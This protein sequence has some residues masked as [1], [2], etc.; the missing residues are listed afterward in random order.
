[1]IQMKILCVAIFTIF[2]VAVGLS[3]TSA[4]AFEL[5]DLHILSGESYPVTNEGTIENEGAIVREI[6]TEIGE[7]MT[8]TAV[9]IRTELTELSSLGPDTIKFSGV[10]EPKTK[11]SCKTA[12]TTVEGEVLSSGEYHV[13]DVN[14]SPLTVAMLLLFPELVVECNKGKLKIKTKPPVIVKVEK[15]NS[16]TD[17]TEYGLVV[18]CTPK[19]KQELKEYF[20]DEGK[21]VKGTLLVNFGLGNETACYRT[22]KELVMKSSKMIDFLF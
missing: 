6:E 7:K 8:A 3:S 13:V 20:N 18:N 19:G 17:V 12:N 16:G 11:T 9:T 22:T 15:V 4:L 21:L 2:A 5:P 1:M 14:E 10:K